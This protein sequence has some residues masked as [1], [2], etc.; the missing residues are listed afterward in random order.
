MNEL[1][2]S[3]M[4][5]RGESGRLRTSR[6]SGALQFADLRRGSRRHARDRTPSSGP[7]KPRNRTSG[8]DDLPAV[9]NRPDSLGDR[10]SGRV[11]PTGMSFDPAPRAVRPAAGRAVSSRRIAP[12]IRAAS[13]HRAEQSRGAMAATTRIRPHRSDP[14]D[15]QCTCPMPHHESR[16]GQASSLT[17]LRHDLAR[18]QAG[19]T[20]WVR[21]S[22][23]VTVRLIVPD[24]DVFAVRGH[25][26]GIIRG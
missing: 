13:R 4:A 10:V 3:R 7:E 17:S 26:Y 12:W 5:K 24:P 16:D 2:R 11:S 15:R 1:D 20:P 23:F 6:C 19:R 14:A 21:Q 25:S 9:E 22:T 8:S 18:S